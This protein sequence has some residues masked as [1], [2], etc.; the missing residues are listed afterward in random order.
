MARAHLVC[1][2]IYGADRLIEQ[3]NALDNQVPADVQTGMRL[4]VRA[5]IER[6][7]RWM[8]NNRRP[9]DRLRGHSR[10]LQR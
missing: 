2:S 5:L 1:R 7:S 8:V 9:P 4:S 10:T 6:A 3:I